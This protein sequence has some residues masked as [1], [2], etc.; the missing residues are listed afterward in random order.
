MD[1]VVPEDKVIDMG[2]LE[3]L[4][5]PKKGETIDYDCGCIYRI[6]KVE[7]GIPTEVSPDYWCSEHDPTIAR[8]EE[9][10]RDG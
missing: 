9:G 3:K 2:E 8:D 1:R 5:K 6:D 10:E 7:N 4:R